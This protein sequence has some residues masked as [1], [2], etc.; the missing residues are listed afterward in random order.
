M[1]I[2]VSGLIFV[3]FFYY[4]LLKKSITLDA[5][6]SKLV[7]CSTINRINQLTINK[8]IDH[9]HPDYRSTCLSTDLS[10]CFYL[11]MQQFWDCVAVEGPTLSTS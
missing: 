7:N 4:S 10:V 6:N 2:K 8:V 3:F 11:L 5:K 9:L 1:K